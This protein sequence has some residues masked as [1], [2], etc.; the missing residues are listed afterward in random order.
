MTRNVRPSARDRR[1][2][3]ALIYR[4][5]PDQVCLCGLE[6][7]GTRGSQDRYVA[8]VMPDETTF[9]VRS[10]GKPH[11]LRAPLAACIHR[12]GLNNDAQRPSPRDRR[13]RNVR[14]C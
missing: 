3:T 10:I 1:Y 4:N 12:R 7:A 8:T 14:R 9:L 13:T 6:P 11:H 5:R 2:L